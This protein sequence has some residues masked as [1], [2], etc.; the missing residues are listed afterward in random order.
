MVSVVSLNT[1]Q[2]IPKDEGWSGDEDDSSEGEN[3]EDTVPDRTF[4]LQENPGQEGG[5]DWIAEGKEVGQCKS[6]T[7]Y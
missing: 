1:M 7:K 5:E 6:N 4:L 2:M 3:S